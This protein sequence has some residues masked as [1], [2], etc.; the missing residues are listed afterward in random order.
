[1]INLIIAAGSFGILLLISEALYRLRGVSA[2]STRKL[3][4][5]VAGLLVAIFP[6]VLTLA[7]VVTLGLGFVVVLAVSQYF[8]LL[9]SIHTVARATWGEIMFP[10]GL[11]LA[12]L[13][14]FRS[15]PTAFQ[16][17]A[18]ILALPDSAAAIIG[19]RWGKHSYSLGGAKKSGEG[20]MAFFIIAVS[21]SLLV[22]FYSG[23]P[24][25]DLFLRSVLVSGAL[26]IVEAIS[27]RG[28]DNFTLPSAAGAL[29]VWLQ[30]L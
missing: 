3:L 14:F 10:L 27:G 22:G 23:L 9:P 18:L 21:V 25:S 20:S 11:L 17:G 28:M 19:Q 29:A 30:L 2:E 4:H 16:Y 26:T 5:T 7:E 15:H 24:L 13:L 12:A 1:M 8:N 6:W